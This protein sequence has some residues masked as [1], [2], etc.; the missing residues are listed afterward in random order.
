[1]A[2]LAELELPDLEHATFD[3][4]EN[5]FEPGHLTPL[6][7]SI[8]TPRA[9][10]PSFERRQPTALG[11][12][13]FGRVVLVKRYNGQSM[14]IKT[15]DIG[16]IAQREYGGVV[17]QGLIEY[18][19]KKMRVEIKVLAQLSPHPHI[20]RFI[21]SSEKDNYLQIATTVAPGALLQDQ[22]LNEA[23]A[24]LAIRQLL[25]VL[26]YCHQQGIA[27][28]DVKPTNIMWDSETRH[29]TLIDFGEARFFTPGR[30]LIPSHLSS[31]TLAYRKLGSINA[32]EIDLYAAALTCRAMLGANT[33]PKSER[34]IE[35]CLHGNSSIVQILENY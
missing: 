20:P 11:R 16:H 30:P 28:L 31:G 23:D 10:I 21:G 5:S 32:V 34:L 13:A 15:I 17:Q 6:G 26:D 7:R 14:A 19:A 18:H 1:M 8:K 33:S 3:T 25:S 35:L 29:L 2:T 12:G 22:I 4:P 24:Q 27:H 9:L